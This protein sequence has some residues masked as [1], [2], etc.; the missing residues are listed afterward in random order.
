MHCGDGR[1]RTAAKVCDGLEH[2]ASATVA[3]GWWIRAAK[4]VDA[5]HTTDLGRTMG[6]RASTP[7]PGNPYGEG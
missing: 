7:E 6:P 3:P 4:D 1:L 5:K 2:P